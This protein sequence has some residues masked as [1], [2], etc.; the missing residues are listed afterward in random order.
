MI[1]L[2]LVIKYTI[3]TWIKK[4]KIHILIL[5]IYMFPKKKAVL[6]IH[7]FIGG[8]YDFDNF[9]NELQLNKNFDVFTF[10][11]NVNPFV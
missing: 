9:H 1:L 8:I 7:G 2:E 6:F 11:V 3:N 5:V 10:V 4:I